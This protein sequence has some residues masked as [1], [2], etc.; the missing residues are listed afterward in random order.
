MRLLVMLLGLD[1]TKH[2]A[3]QCFL[4]DTIRSSASIWIVVDVDINAIGN[5]EL[6]PWRTMAELINMRTN[7]SMTQAARII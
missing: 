4:R 1:G 2:S 5:S 3:N 6:E 7:S